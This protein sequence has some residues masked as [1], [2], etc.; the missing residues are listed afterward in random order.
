MWPPPPDELASQVRKT[1]RER[2]RSA[3]KRSG[4]H[5]S[6][7]RSRTDRQ[8]NL[9]LD[10]GVETA[11]E[12]EQPN[13]SKSAGVNDSS[14]ANSTLR[15]TVADSV[16]E[17]KFATQPVFISGKLPL[18]WELSDKLELLIDGETM[19]VENQIQFYAPNNLLAHPLVS[20]ALGYVGG[21]PPLLVIAGDG[22]VLRDEIIF[23]SGS[24]SLLFIIVLTYWQGA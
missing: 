12:A 5:S 16:L 6:F 2:F 17:K 4:V 22:E 23:L 11:P 8:G 10:S 24:F 14:S 21:L 9:A 3:A 18:P 19:T 7:L 20:P 15:M 1:L 13:V